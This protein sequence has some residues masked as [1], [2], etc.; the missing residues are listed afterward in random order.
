MLARRR[1]SVKCFRMWH[2]IALL[3][4]SGLVVAS[5]MELQPLNLGEDTPS[6]SRTVAQQGPAVEVVCEQEVAWIDQA[7]LFSGM[8][9][10]WHETWEPVC[11]NGLP[12]VELLGMNGYEIGSFM[13]DVKEYIAL[14]GHAALQEWLGECKRNSDLLI[15]VPAQVE[16][17]PMHKRVCWDETTGVYLGD[18]T[19][20]HV[21]ECTTCRIAVTYDKYE[22]S[23]D[24]LVFC[25]TDGYN[26]SVFGTSY[27]DSCSAR[28][29]REWLVMG[30]EVASSLH[31]EECKDKR[32]D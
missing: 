17:W 9:T 3:G 32:P 15:R 2:N 19:I 24:N 7:Q 4:I 12:N 8:G 22:C 11:L 28:A 1:H 21:G 14:D 25:D 27:D 23:D 29:R 20:D 26:Y 5:S 31:K 30:E 18:D 16:I 6:D 13:S 10:V